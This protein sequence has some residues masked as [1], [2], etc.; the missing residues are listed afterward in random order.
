MKSDSKNFS[1]REF[2]SKS[3][4]GLASAGILGSEILNKVKSP[5]QQK[6]N[7]LIYRTLGKT[8][9]KVP[10]IGMGVMNTTDEAVMARS[11]DVGV[12]LFDT[13]LRYENE[14]EVGNFIKTKG[15]REKVVLETKVPVPDYLKPGSMTP[16]QM[17][18]KFLQ[19]FDGCLERLQTDYVDVLFLHNIKFMRD[20]N[21]QGIIDALNKIKDSKR[22]RFIGVS[23]HTHMED[24]L[25]EA[26]NQKE[27]YSVV[28]IALTFAMT[29]S[30]RY[31]ERYVNILKAI[32]NAASNDL[33]IIAM[34][35]QAMGG[36]QTV[37]KP[38]HTAALK[39]ALNQKGITCAIPGY[40][41]FDQMEEDFSV[42]YDIKYT[43]EEKIYL[44]DKNTQFGVNFC[45]QCGECKPGCPIKVD[46]PTLMRSH[47]YASSYSNFLQS[48]E[49]LKEIPVGYGL[50]N[51]TSC[52]TCAAKCL[53]ITD[54]PFK[55]NELKTL[56]Y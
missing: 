6:N 41:N 8:G 38:H 7:K 25:D 32:E 42:A 12:R 17:N 31:A 55:I 37:K 3:S 2:L 4:T 18:K 48:R 47:M 53:N 15:I 24:V 56:Y 5:F 46:I 27:L 35:T 14:N 30:P 39:W 43:E 40:T 50:D 34:K 13:A 45:F 28:Q 23:T 16:L 36:K 29:Y 22:A 49:A 11:Y 21:N 10:V 26:V 51:C 19:D 1:R 33:G 44:E 20:M 52:S 54:I 9:L